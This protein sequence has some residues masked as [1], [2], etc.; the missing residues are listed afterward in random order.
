MRG[1]T[2]EKMPRDENGRVKPTA[3]QTY[4]LATIDRLT[5]QHG[6]APTVR[7]LEAALSAKS[8]N[9]IAQKLRLLKRKGWVEW[10][11]H[12]ARTLRVTGPIGGAA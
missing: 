1:L 12:K 10:Q 4:L 9:S 5:K 11:P 7:E 6:Y 3:K 2:I 8:P